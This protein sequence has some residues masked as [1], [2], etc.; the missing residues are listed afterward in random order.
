METTLTKNQTAKVQTKTGKDLDTPVI[1]YGNID[2][3]SY[4]LLDRFLKKHKVT[5]K[6]FITNPKYVVVIDGDEHY[7]FQKYK[8]LGL[9]PTLEVVE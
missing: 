9:L 6:E 8:A 5:L 1:E 4:G 2:H 7:T 3:Q